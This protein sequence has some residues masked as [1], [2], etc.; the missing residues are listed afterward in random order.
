MSDQVHVSEV[1]HW[2]ADQEW[3]PAVIAKEKQD[4]CSC[5]SN[6][7]V[8]HISIVGW[9]VRVNERTPTGKDC[10]VWLHPDD[11]AKIAQHFGKP[12]FGTPAWICRNILLMD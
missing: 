6:D 7:P 1:G 12:N 2:P 11:A 3:Y 8:P 10:H 5:D 9:K 4:E